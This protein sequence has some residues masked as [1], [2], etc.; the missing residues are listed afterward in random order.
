MR[1]LFLILALLLVSSCAST[2]PISGCSPY[3]IG[4]SPC[5]PDNW[6]ETW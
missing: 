4:D 1:A 3:V 5:V 6:V 2:C